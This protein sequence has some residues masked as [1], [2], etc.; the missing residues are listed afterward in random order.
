M[1]NESVNPDSR[2]ANS[3]HGIGYISSYLPKLN[4]G[5]ELVSETHFHEMSD[6]E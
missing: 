3:S 1:Q 4:S 6:F 5:L 2:I